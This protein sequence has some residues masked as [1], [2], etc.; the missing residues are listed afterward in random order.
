MASKRQRKDGG[1]DIRFGRR[2]K[3][4]DYRKTINIGDCSR[5]EAVIASMHIQHLY[6]CQELETPISL[7]TQKWLNERS[8]TVHRRISDKGLCDERVVIGEASDWYSQQQATLRARLDKFELRE[9]ARH[10]QV[11]CQTVKQLCDHFLV[12]KVVEDAADGSITKY[13]QCAEKVTKFF[14]KSTALSSI[15][16]SR[17]QDFMSWLKREGGVNR[18]TGE[19]GEPM[20]KTTVSRH[21][22]YA[23]DMFGRAESS[24][25]I[26]KHRFNELFAKA[27][28]DV[29][30]D[31]ARQCNV[32]A[33]TMQ[34]IIDK[35]A[36][37]NEQKL[38]FA[39]ARWMMIRVPSELLP[40][41]WACVDWET[42]KMF[43]RAPKQHGHGWKYER[44]SPIWPEVMPYLQQ[45]WQEA[46]EGDK[47]GFV[48]HRYRS[49]K[50]DTN[51]HA[52]LLKKAAHRAGLTSHR[53]DS[54]WP[55]LFI[56]CKSTRITELRMEKKFTPDQVNYWANHREDTSQKHYQQ[57][58]QWANFDWRAA[59]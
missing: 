22:R 8:D 11:Q 51:K 49:A 16:P 48:I 20:A 15:T 30:T 27:P 32:P 14:R 1:W 44:W 26:T 43:L 33:E 7:R 59:T 17:M 12:W 21:I 2:T 6:E 4:K 3:L 50:N 55:K 24:G 13:Q 57:V 56:N 35:G 25:W 58:E 29:R 23:R 42:E 18:K 54:P 5:K 45:Q 38:I 9:A 39:M 19:F 36:L 40:I 28:R 53:D 46:P 52:S 34:L 10:F 37:N 47:D 41:T 31:V